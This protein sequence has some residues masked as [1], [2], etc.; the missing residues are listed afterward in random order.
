MIKEKI[1]LINDSSC[2]CQKCLSCYQ[3]S[4]VLEKCPKLH[5]IPSSESIIKKLNF[6]FFNQRLPFIRTRKRFSHS[7]KT[8][9]SN[10]L[11]QKKMESN[12]KISSKMEQSLAFSNNTSDDDEKT[13]KETLE[14]NEKNISKQESS[15]HEEIIKQDTKPLSDEKIYITQASATMNNNENDPPLASFQKLRE[16]MEKEIPSE[17]LMKN[18]SL[19]ET[20]KEDKGKK[21]V[22]QGNLIDFREGILKKFVCSRNIFQIRIL[23]K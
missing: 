16:G 6:P 3:F 17:Y 7:L 14:E 22:S 20:L 2:I 19:K 13:G 18:K 15:L 8:K 9:F 11:A 23:I 4:H 12:L 10:Q 5:Y 1:L 21:I